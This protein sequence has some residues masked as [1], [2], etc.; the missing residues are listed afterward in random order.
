MRFEQF[1]ARAHAV[2][3]EIPAPYKEGVDGI[4]VTRRTVL[5][6]TL[7]D[8]FTLGEC[9]SEQYPSGFGGG[10]VR[11]MI[12]LYYGSFLELSRQ[13]EEWD[14][15]EEI[16]ETITHEI[17]HHLEHL[18]DDDALVDAD[19]AD[20]HN[21]ARREG[22]P[23]DPFFFRGGELV[24]ERL[25]DVS[26]DLFYEHSGA[27]IRNDRDGRETIVLELGEWR[28]RVAVP[29]EDA[30]V[31]YLRIDDP[32]VA[33]RGDFY[34]VVERPRGALRGFV[35]LLRGRALRVVESEAELLPS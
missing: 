28:V 23:F 24:A 11:S 34:L 8:V 5:H 31:H 17:R 15:E 19:I 1:S 32:P 22:Q 6:P 12:H 7:P 16:F 29:A 13:D 21:F 2:F 10:E 26:G 9:L 35:N 33:C 14:W 3:D 25:F 4:E 27:E 30:D 20:D 18:A